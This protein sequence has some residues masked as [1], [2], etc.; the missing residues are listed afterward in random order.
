MQPV[1]YQSV[2]TPATYPPLW[3]NDNNIHRFISEGHCNVSN[4]S[5]LS[6]NRKVQ[7]C[8]TVTP[9]IQNQ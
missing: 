8:H 2:S 7:N 9:A 1:S 3:Q 4:T 6:W 5:M